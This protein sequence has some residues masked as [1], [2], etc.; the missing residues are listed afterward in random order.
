[1]TN[2]YD[3]QEGG[4]HYKGMAIQP[5]QFSM[6]NGLDACTHT[7]IKYLVRKKGDKAKRAEDLRKAIH[8]IQLLAQHEGIEL[9]DTSCRSSKNTL[10]H[11]DAIWQAWDGGAC[12][13]PRDAWVVVRFRDGEIEADRAAN[14]RWRRSK[15]CPLVDVV[16]YYVADETR[17]S[18]VPAGKTQSY[19]IERA[20]TVQRINARVKAE[21]E[22]DFGHRRASPAA[23]ADGWIKWEGGECPVGS[24]ARVDIRLRSGITRVLPACAPS[25]ENYGNGWDIIA[26]RLSKEASQ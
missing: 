17:V 12:P 18:S 25:W 13:V 2:P 5:M 7:A 20:E 16:A 6:A 9:G 4:S 26:Y 10:D 1:M 21:I 24:D 14:V 15:A 23:D 8:C 3:H 19:C 22:R 11:D